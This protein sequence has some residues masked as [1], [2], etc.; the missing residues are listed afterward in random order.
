MRDQE[1]LNTGAQMFQCAFISYTPNM[2][3]PPAPPELE[4]PN[5]N[6][7]TW[8]SPQLAADGAAPDA[9]A[10]RKG[11]SLEIRDNGCCFINK[12]APIER[13]LTQHIKIACRHS[14]EW[15]VKGW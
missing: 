8:L 3:A 4:R 13:F 10:S 5:S 12:G 15:L 11:A 9:D 14:G 1:R 7:K 6:T 2:P